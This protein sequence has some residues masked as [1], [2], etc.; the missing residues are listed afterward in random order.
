MEFISK[1]KLQLMQNEI[2]TAVRS[3]SWTT[4]ED[5]EKVFANAVTRS[6]DARFE[7]PYIR[8]EPLVKG[9][10]CTVLIKADIPTDREGVNRL[11]CDKPAQ[12][13]HNLSFRLTFK[14]KTFKE[15]QES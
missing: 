8:I 6:S 2:E 15:A 14:R 11:E 12:L 3:A 4:V 9:S 5:V 1:T 7:N 10:P 13:S